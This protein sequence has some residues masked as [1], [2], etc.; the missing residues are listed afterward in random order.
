MSSRVYG[1]RETSLGQQALWFIQQRSADQA[2]YNV[3]FSWKIPSDTDL[4]V[5]ERALRFLVERHEMLRSVFCFRNGSLVRDVLTVWQP[6]SQCVDVGHIDD[7]KMSTDYIAPEVKKTFDLTFEPPQRYLLFKRQGKQSVFTFVIHH[8]TLDLHSHMLWMDELKQVYACFER[9]EIPN[10][11]S[12]NSHFDDYVIAQ[13]HYLDGE[14]GKADAAYWLKRIRPESVAVSL[15]FDH[16]KTPNTPCKSG[17]MSGEVPLALHQDILALAKSLHMSAYECYFAAYSVFLSKIC[18]QKTVTIGTP[19]GGRDGKYTDVYGYFVNTLVVQTEVNDKLTVK[20]NLQ[21]IVAGIRDDMAHSRYPAALLSELLQQEQGADTA[22]LFQTTFLWE[23]TNRFFHR[24]TPLVSWPDAQTRL[25]DM[26]ALGTWERIPRCQQVDDLDLT[27][28]CYKFKD[29]LFWAIEYNATL[30]EAATVAELSD[31][32]QHLLMNVLAHPTALLRDV[33]LRTE[34]GRQRAVARARGEISEYNRQQYFVERLGYWGR[35]R[36]DAIAVRDGQLTIS[37]QQLNTTV[38]R[39]AHQLI[40]QG[41]SRED[42]V[43]VAVGRSATFLVA[44]LAV[45]KAGAAYLPLDISYPKARLRHIVLD[46]QPEL[47]LSTEPENVDGFTVRVLP[48][49]PITGQQELTLVDTN[50]NILLNDQDLAYVIYTSG[51]TGKPKGVEISHGNTAAM[52]HAQQQVLQLPPQQNILQFASWSFDASVFEIGSMLASGGCLHISAKENMLGSELL[53]V[54][55]QRQ[56]HCA[57]LPPSLLTFC[58]PKE[59][60]PH[61]HTLIVGGDR[62]SADVVANWA[63]GRRFFNAYGPSEATVFCTI[64]A[65]IP[66]A[67]ITIGRSIPNAQVYVL[68]EQ[69]QLLPPGRLGEIYI[70]GD[71]VGRG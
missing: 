14:Q 4:V 54:L 3:E 65:L 9:G 33:S 34:A 23:N 18:Q 49:P 19:T 39:L 31:S 22:G 59:P 21:N 41:I 63:K 47:I 15:P 58:P 40:A 6:S 17:Y 27:F 26:Q 5:L 69:Q 48:L 66:E 2:V 10:L 60:L 16:P 13:K 51:S 36:A 50:P 29:R 67:D 71:G 53:S 12:I 57:I 61:L 28:K 35:C 24:E 68:D 55:Q 11:P 64:Q 56:I 46:A 42:L 43:G 7:S 37:Y 44:V 1:E 38:S 70:G 8:I 25:W 20:N 45:P 32:F 62:C 30:F 52:M